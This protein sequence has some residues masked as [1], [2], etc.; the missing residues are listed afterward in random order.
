M[1]SHA[2]M[3]RDD[4]IDRLIA[5]SRQLPDNWDE[6]GPRWRELYGGE[7]PVSAR[8][9]F[10]WTDA[11]EDEVSRFAAA[12]DDAR[13]AVT[14]AYH[15]TGNTGQPKQMQPHRLWDLHNDPERMTAAMMRYSD[16]EMRFTEARARANDPA[17]EARR[18][19]SL[20]REVERRLA[21]EAEDQRQQREQDRRIEI[22]LEIWTIDCGIADQEAWEIE[23]FGEIVTTRRLDGLAI[24]S[25][26]F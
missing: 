26:P 22:A 1:T 13:Q 14:A 18:E 16:R 11:P 15:A 24:P 17:R 7:P 4:V 3:D 21:A 8:R 19:R 5:E 25:V 10:P 23:T 9:L 20:S 12:Y 2:W 6:V